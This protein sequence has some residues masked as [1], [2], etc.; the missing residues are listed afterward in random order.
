[1]DIYDVSSEAERDICLNAEEHFKQMSTVFLQGL[2]FTATENISDWIKRKQEYKPNIAVPKRFEELMNENFSFQCN[3]LFAM[4]SA[5]IN[6]DID[7]L[8]RSAHIFVDTI[9]SKICPHL[10]KLFYND[11]AM[12]THLFSKNPKI[13]TCAGIDIFSA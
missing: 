12:C 9:N 7:L 13:L 3:F 5:N 1:M 4:E 8:H 10:H 11:R 6:K 2:K